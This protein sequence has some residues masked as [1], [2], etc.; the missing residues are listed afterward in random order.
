VDQNM[1]WMAKS[2]CF[3]GRLVIKTQQF[4]VFESFSI[5][6]RLF[7]MLVAMAAALVVNYLPHMASCRVVV[8]RVRVQSSR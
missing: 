3:Y 7:V 2:E 6:S 8:V 1:L 4:S 5:S